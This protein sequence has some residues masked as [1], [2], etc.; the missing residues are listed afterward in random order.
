VGA[1]GWVL[2]ML[3]VLAA[4]MALA[5]PWALPLVFGRPFASSYG[6]LLVLLP[7]AVLLGFQTIIGQ[8]FGARAYPWFVARYWLAGLVLNLAANAYALPR[9]GAVG[10]AAASTLGYAAVTGLVWR[11]FARETGLSA[12][13]LWRG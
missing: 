6:P 3:T 10:A 12:R 1:G 7:G 2:G 5:G 4:V 9:F 11:R 13:A 8:Y